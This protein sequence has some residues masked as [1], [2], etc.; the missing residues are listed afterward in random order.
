MPTKNPDAVTSEGSRRL[1]PLKRYLLIASITALYFVPVI[2][3][4]LSLAL[5]GA[6]IDSGVDDFEGRERRMASAALLNVDLHWN[7]DDMMTTQAPPFSTAWRV[8]SVEKCPGTPSGR[9]YEEM[10]KL[11]YGYRAEVEFY[12]ILGIPRG[13][14]HIQCESDPRWEPYY[15]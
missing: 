8:R 11:A 4:Y 6:F 7:A 1:A 14:L 2:L 3:L 10:I 13:M 9:E 5:P 12:T 15:R